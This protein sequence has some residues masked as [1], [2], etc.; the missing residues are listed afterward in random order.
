MKMTIMLPLCALLLA[1][2][3]LTGC[4]PVSLR[5]EVTHVSHISQHF[6][7]DPTNYGYNDVALDLHLEPTRHMMIDV[8]DGIILNHGGSNHGV[9]YTGAMMGPREVFSATVGWDIPLWR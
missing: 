6:S 2:I 1:A 8:S 3:L 5:P 7:S 4:C 9:Q